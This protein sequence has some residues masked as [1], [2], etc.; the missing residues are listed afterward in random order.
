MAQM[1]LYSIR[2]MH[3]IRTHT[4]IRPVRA[5]KVK[6]EKEGGII[7]V[8]NALYALGY[9]TSHIRHT[10]IDQMLGCLPKPVIENVLYVLEQEL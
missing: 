9:R 10:G 8:K 4:T 2:R 3:P 5:I 6:A 7:A 1:G